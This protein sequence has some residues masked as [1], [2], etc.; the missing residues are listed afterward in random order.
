MDRQR[1]ESKDP[2]I[3]ERVRKLALED[4]KKLIPRKPHRLNDISERFKK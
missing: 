3:S 2:K 4:I 1:R